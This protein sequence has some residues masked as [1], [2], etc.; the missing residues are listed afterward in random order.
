[1]TAATTTAVATLLAFAVPGLVLRSL[2]VRRHKS[3]SGLPWS[4]I[5]CW[6]AAAVACFVTNPG[7][8][9]L[10]A[11]IAAGRSIL[12]KLVSRWEREGNIYS[13]G[14]CSVATYDGDTYFGVLSTWVSASD[15][16][17][18]GTSADFS[19]LFLA[20]QVVIFLLW[21]YFGASSEAMADH[22]TSSWHNLRR[23][24][25]WTLITGPLSHIQTFHFILNLTSMFRLL[26]AFRD[27]P[28]SLPKFCLTAAVSSAAASVFWHGIV[29][30]HAVDLVGCS[31]VVY[32]LHAALA[33]H[34]PSSQIHAFGR[35]L[36]AFQMLQLRLC[37]DV[38]FFLVQGGSFRGVDVPCHVGGMLAGACLATC[39]SPTNNWLRRFYMAPRRD[40]WWS[41][42]LVLSNK[43]PQ[44]AVSVLGIDAS[45]GSANMCSSDASL[46]LLTSALVLGVCI[47]CRCSDQ[48]DMGY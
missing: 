28:V 12:R 43:L 37:I 23:G 33:L 27:L 42:S 2:A 41:P 11:K 46:V 44:Q 20:T 13:Y 22:F 45:S 9:E 1:M 32:A 39:S 34:L 38:G 19:T 48:H 5:A 8:I 14:W 16:Q 40:W 10:H 31:G 6:S 3:R 4:T 47:W 36:T 30:R 7:T 18:L 29:R 15:F 25:M 24:R 35:D 21:Q 17:K 26:E